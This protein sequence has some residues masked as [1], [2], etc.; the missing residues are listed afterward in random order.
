[1]MDRLDGIPLVKESRQHGL[2]TACRHP[3][4]SPAVLHSVHS[5]RTYI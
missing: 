5:S 2:D 4:T 3:G 1:M